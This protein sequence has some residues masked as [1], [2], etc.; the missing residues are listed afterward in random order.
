MKIKVKYLLIIIILLVSNMVYSQS[1]DNPL[2]KPEGDPHP[3]L[4]I[5]GGISYLL[6]VGAAYGIY[7]LKKNKKSLS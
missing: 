1:F 4:P 5:N 3:E 6:I 2:P 7:V